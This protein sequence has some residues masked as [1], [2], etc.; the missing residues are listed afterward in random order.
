M[1]EISQLQ[2]ECLTRINNHPGC[3]GSCCANHY[4]VDNLCDECDCSACLNHIQ[5]DNQPSF[6]YSCEKITFHYVLRFFNRFSSEICHLLNQCK[7]SSLKELNVISL[8]CGPASELYG[9]VKSVHSRYPNIKLHF[10][11]YDTNSCWA[12]VQNITKGLLAKDGLIVNFHCKDIFTDYV[13]AFQNK[14]AILVLNYVLSDMVKFN[15]EKT[16]QSI[17]SQ[18]ADFVRAHNIRVILF[19]DIRYYGDSD[20]LN[21]GV[22]LMKLIL[23]NLSA[24][25]SEIERHYLYFDGDKYVGNEGWTPYKSNNLLFENLPDNPYIINV[26]S[27]GSKQILAI[28]K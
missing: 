16:N 5:W 20:K 24:A 19:N 14:P 3:E 11:G 18:L 17:A 26:G 12:K 1:R 23:D 22:Q 10:E 7:I 13:D 21:S 9:L 27:C 25:G 15:D 28:V 4:C 6:R 8:G 2:Q